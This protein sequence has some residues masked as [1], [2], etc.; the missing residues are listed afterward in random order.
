[1]ASM[2]DVAKKANV[3]IATVS[4]VVNKSGFVS[5]ETKEIV[6]KV[7]D[8]LGY[9][10]NELARNFQ[11][12]QTNTI[13]LIIPNVTQG[14]TSEL[15]FNLEQALYNIGYHVQ[16]CISNH[17]GSKELEHLE[18]LKSQQVTGVIITAPFI[19]EDESLQFK[20][21]AI[22]SVDRY[23]NE[24]IPCVHVDNYL[25]STE[26]THHL[27]KNTNK[28]IAY[29]GFGADKNS[30]SNKRKDAFINL[31]YQL[32][33][34]YLLFE[35]YFKESV[36]NYIKRIFNVID[37]CDGFYFSCD[38]YAHHFI[39]YATS[40]GYSVGTDYKVVG[41]D[42]LSTN[43]NYHYQLTCIKQPLN[44]MSKHVVNALMKRINNSSVEMDLVTEYEFIKGD[45][46]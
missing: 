6:L 17:D 1:M 32:D 34:D 15:T 22:V 23:V 18:K 31:C 36:N 24:N 33:K 7:I 19:S 13:G 41:F 27:I 12:K 29:I 37:V 42:G 25:A 40:K 46:C 2:K 20:D 14:F 43:N 35:T 30:L 9:V 5:K 39:S 26:L 28:D 45:T 4:R 8:E 16:L 44:I 11:K 3:G 10:P 38:Y 21:L